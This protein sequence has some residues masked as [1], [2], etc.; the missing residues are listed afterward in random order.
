MLPLILFLC[1]DAKPRQA[2]M[3]PQAPTIS[4]RCGDACPLG[5]GCAVCSCATPKPASLRP[6]GEGWQWDAREGCWWR[7][8]PSATATVISPPTFAPVR[9]APSYAIRG[10]VCAG[11]G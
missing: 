4:C 10:A 5:G 3:P 8:V 7:I 6:D 9:L 11:G 1:L 2:P